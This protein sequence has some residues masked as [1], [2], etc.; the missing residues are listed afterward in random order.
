MNI[1]GGILRYYNNDNEDNTNFNNIKTNQN[2][3]RNWTIHTDRVY[4]VIE[5]LIN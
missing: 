3:Q 1:L 2:E 5:R 4:K